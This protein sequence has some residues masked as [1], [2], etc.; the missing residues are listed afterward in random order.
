MNADESCHRVDIA[1][2]GVVFG[3]SLL[4]LAYTGQCGGN[5]TALCEFRGLDATA[6][7]AH[8]IGHK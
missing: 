2:S 6:I 3:N 5:G 1:L 8:E 4:G 7:T